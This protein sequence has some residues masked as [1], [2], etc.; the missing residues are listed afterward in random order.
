MADR[1][2]D[3]EVLTHFEG[4]GQWHAQARRLNEHGN[5]FIELHD[6]ARMLQDRGEAKAVQLV[7][8]AHQLLRDEKFEDAAEALR[9]AARAADA[10]NPAY[11]Q[12]L[13]LMAD[14]LPAR[15]V[16]PP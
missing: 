12:G 7:L 9:A 11:A 3:R 10:K 2:Q 15:G 1:Q 8:Q 5:I 16:P 13:R 4:I 14:R 6:A